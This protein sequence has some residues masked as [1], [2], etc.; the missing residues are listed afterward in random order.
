AGRSDTYGNNWE[1]R[2]MGEL[3]DRLERLAEHRA[4]QIPA[5][6]MPPTDELAV[7]RG[8]MR[9]HRLVVA[10]AACVAFA[11]VIGGLLIFAHDS[12]GPTVETP[13]GTLPSTT[14]GG[15]TGKAYVNNSA[16]GT[17][18]VLDTTTGAVTA[19]IPVGQPEVGGQNG[20]FISPDG[21][22][23]YVTHNLDGTATVISTATD[24]VVATIPLGKEPFSIT[25]SPDSSRAYVTHGDE[26]TLTVISTA[27]GQV[28]ATLRVGES[29]RVPQPNPI[30][31]TMTPAGKHL[32]INNTDGTL[33]VITTGTG[34]ASAT[35][36]VGTGPGEIAFTPDGKDAYVA[37]QTDGTV[38][39]ITTAN[40]A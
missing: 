30:P 18:S 20:P 3:E 31:S 40:G 28:A 29:R 38:S 8:V 12:H 27:T 37:N 32:Y 24:S 36:D 10:I 14:D 11:L 1:L 23:L 16:H 25:F 6:S 15:C 5:F 21:K 34:A 7:R 35:I 2:S 33:S 13:A 17:L 22:Q 39:V 26:G 4:A 19:T 9:R